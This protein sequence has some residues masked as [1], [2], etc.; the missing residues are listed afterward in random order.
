[1]RALVILRG[2]HSKDVPGYS[3][4]TGITASYV[5]LCAGRV[6]YIMLAE[7]IVIRNKLRIKILSSNKNKTAPILKI[8]HVR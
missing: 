1:M 7:L 2:K 8:H 3:K 6:F 5:S 4:L